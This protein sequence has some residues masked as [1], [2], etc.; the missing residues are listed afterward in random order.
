[1]AHLILRPD[2]YL[3]DRFATP[4]HVYLNRRA[5]LSGLGAA[6]ATALWG[7]CD[8][9]RDGDAPAA[10][11]SAAESA[12]DHEASVATPPARPS[13]VN[14]NPRYVL[15]RPITDE[16]VAAQ[17]NNFYEFTA[18]KARVSELVDGFET[19]PWRIAV[20]GEC[21]KTGEFDLDDLIRGIPVEERLYRFR[22][23]EAW[24]MA[25]PWMGIPLAA[26][27]GKL[28]PNSRA[29]FV[30][31]ETFIRPEQAPGQRGGNL[32]WPYREGLTLAEATNELALMATGIYGHDLPKQHGAPIRLV[33]PWKY[34]YKSIKSIV[35]IHFTAN[36]PKTTWPMEMPGEYDFKANVNPRKPHPRWSQAIEWMID[37]KT[38]YKTRL[39]NGYGEQVAYLYG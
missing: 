13:Y 29:A 19:A 35:R 5:F 32:N 24:A 10:S 22:C 33:V 37:T 26:L 39:Y 1:M 15:D 3:P 11:A 8:R 25:V 14:R 30:E 2:W 23:V 31:F 20:T 7:G 38:T 6:G 16:A 9:G 12:P 18:D 34:G 4:E 36:Q 17:Y 28:E 27:I 21:N